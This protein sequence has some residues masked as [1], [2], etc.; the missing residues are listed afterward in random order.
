M[1]EKRTLS[2]RI[3]NTKLRAEREQYRGHRSTRA[4]DRDC[5]SFWRAKTRDGIF[6]IHKRGKFYR[7]SP[8]GYLVQE[9]RAACEP[10]IT[11]SHD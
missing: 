8:A 11:V 4:H 3:K 6:F 1:T 5:H 2:D 7:V 9:L 10:D